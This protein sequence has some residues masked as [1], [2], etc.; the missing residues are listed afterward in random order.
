MSFLPQSRQAYLGVAAKEERHSADA[1]SEWL[2][3]ETTHI[4]A[5]QRSDV[6]DNTARTLRDGVRAM[7]GLIRSI[8]GAQ[9]TSW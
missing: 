6:A 7:N 5:V 1:Q 8:K 9:Q 2:T 3:Y 4:N